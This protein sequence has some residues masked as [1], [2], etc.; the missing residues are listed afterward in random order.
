MINVDHIK[1]QYGVVGND[2][3]LNHALEVA[4][5]VA[6]TD[7]TV[8]VT[9]ENGTGKDV[10][11]R[12]IHDNSP[13]KHNK[14]MA[15][16]CGGI[17]EGTL[18]SELFGHVKGAFTSALQDRKG[19]FEEADG[20]TLFLDEVGDLPMSTQVRL[21]R[22]L[23]NGEYLRVGSSEVRK[24]NVRVI[25]ATNVDLPQAIENGRFRKD[26]Y[27]RLNT[28]PIH[29][30]ALRE[31]KDD[32]EMLFFKFSLEIA[33]LQ[34]VRPVQLTPEAMEVLKN[35][36]WEGNIRQLQNFVRQL[37]VLTQGSR[38]IDENTLMKYLPQEHFNSMPTLFH[39]GNDTISERDLLY[40]V[41]FDMKRDIT[42]LRQT[43]AEMKNSGLY[44]VTPKY[45]DTPQENNFLDNI[46]PTYDSEPIEMVEQT[47]EIPQ[48]D[49][50]A[51][52]QSL[53][54][55]QR[56]AIIS[57]LERNKGCKR[58]TARDLGISER[59]LYRKI[60]EFGL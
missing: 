36:R 11:P 21:L 7:L 30:P 53:T 51:S 28:M 33:E 32:I 10:I 48:H 25:A 42:E 46:V 29:I 27:F 1:S 20:G 17:P 9:G 4:V 24:T 19:Y 35:Q 39:G 5:Q 56:D 14:F 60:K 49:D 13:R 26:L 59:T 16:N 57:A 58:D 40:K 54:D 41:L 15:V 8:L 52:K 43:I 44:H 45:I 22:V 2:P 18:D 3:M 6:S 12:I 34:H 37:S 38:L 31:R 47:E 50:N 23:E 55:M